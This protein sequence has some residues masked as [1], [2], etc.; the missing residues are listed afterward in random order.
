MY[1][2]CAQRIYVHRISSLV[3]F[4]WHNNLHTGDEDDWTSMDDAK[5]TETKQ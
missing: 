1:T 4:L 5:A 3:Y 2:I